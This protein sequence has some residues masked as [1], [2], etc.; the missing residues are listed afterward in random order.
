MA[1]KEVEP[2]YSNRS[3]IDRFALRL[4]TLSVPGC[5]IWLGTKKK[6]GYGRAE[7]PGRGKKRNAHAIALEISLGRRLLEGSQ[8]NHRDE[9]CQRKD[10]CN[11]AHLYEGT[12]KENFDDAMRAGKHRCSTMANRTA[13]KN[14][15]AFDGIQANGYRVCKTCMS[16]AG[17]RSRERIRAGLRTRRNKVATRECGHGE[18]AK[19]LDRY[20]YARCR[21]CER[22]RARAKYVLGNPEARKYRSRKKP[23]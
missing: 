23:D 6:S 7:E 18:A 8:A 1:Q 17:R 16:E 5:H 9:L 10:C 22:E 11:P 20:E 13:C 4:D 21:G 12:K 19:Y 3:Y 14:G 2:H 15:H